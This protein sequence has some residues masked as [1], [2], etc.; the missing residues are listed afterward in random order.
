MKTI[1]IIF[2]LSLAGCEPMTSYT[3]QS[4]YKEKYEG[5]PEKG[6]VTSTYATVKIDWES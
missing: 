1:L 6:L 4:E 3:T 5:D 2:C